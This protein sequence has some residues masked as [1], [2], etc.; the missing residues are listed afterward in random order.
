MS[1]T[2]SLNTAVSS[3]GAFT[4]AIQ[5]TSNNIAN[6]STPGYSRQRVQLQAAAGSG[7]TGQGVVLQGYQS[8]R[9][10]LIQR[11]LQQQT[12]AQ[13][14]ADAQASTLQQIQPTFT[15][16]TQDIGTQMSALF[17]TISTLS[18]NPGSSLQRQA[19]LSAGQNLATA[20]HTT[21]ESLTSQ[22][23]GINTQVTSDVSQINL[24]T[25]Q[26]AALNPQLAALHES[27]QDG[28][29][30]QDQQDKLVMSLSKLTDVMVTKTSNGDSLTT[31]AGAML[32]V[33]AQSF[34]LQTTNVAGS[35]N[36][37][38]SNGKDI[39][40]TLTGGDLGGSIKMR[41][42]VIGGLLSDLNALANQFGTAMNQAQAQGFDRNG[43]VG[44]NFYNVTAMGAAASISMAI[45][46]PALVAASSDGSAGSTGNLVN[47]SAIQTTAL[48]AGKTPS[49]TYANLVYSVGNLSANAKAES[50]ATAV[51]LVQ[52]NNQNN[53]VSGVSINEESVN[54]LNFQ[55]AYAASARVVTT[56][57]A[58]FQITLSMGT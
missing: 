12:Q 40:A 55:Q 19:V 34:A 11:Q 41:D 18:T 44:Q 1:L 49:D 52:L 4:A 21:S 35:Q 32:V 29:S 23:S 31:T 45:T 26:I 56:I 8:V 17:A 28:G 2:S 46:D 42:Q 5:T 36:V 43:N 33:G 13:G 24:L 25:Q 20:F 50:A 47:L 53:S 27:G 30:V 16:S 9:S 57:Q 7:S 3:I 38:D 15:T 6:A 14:S 10:E 22:Q 39:T 58:L 37:L 48:P 51:S 54:L